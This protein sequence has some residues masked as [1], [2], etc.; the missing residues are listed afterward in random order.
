VEVCWNY[1]P[2]TRELTI[3]CLQAPFF[4]SAADVDAKIRSL[5]EESL[6]T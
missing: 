3:Q 6:A 5:V 2:E 1:S 4:L